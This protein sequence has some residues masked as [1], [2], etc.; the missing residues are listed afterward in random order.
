MSERPLIGIVYSDCAMRD[1]DMRIRTYVSKKYSNAVLQ[2]GGDPILLPVPFYK[3]IT[4]DE[5]TR[6]V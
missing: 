5:I 6:L 3:G 1:N 4:K 2:S